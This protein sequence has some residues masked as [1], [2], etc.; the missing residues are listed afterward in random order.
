[1]ARHGQ[2]VDHLDGIGN[3]AVQIDLMTRREIHESEVVVN[4]LYYLEELQELVDELN[5]SLDFLAIES[6]RL[7]FSLRVNLFEEN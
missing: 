3:L 6:F 1:M 5:R 7:G 2:G 4:V